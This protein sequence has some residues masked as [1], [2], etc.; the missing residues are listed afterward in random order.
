MRILFSRNFTYAKFRE[1][2]ALVKFPNLQYFNGKILAR[3]P[4]HTEITS[5]TEIEMNGWLDKFKRLYLNLNL[6][7]I[8]TVC[9]ISRNIHISY[10]TIEYCVIRLRLI[11][12][13]YP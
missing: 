12:A 11:T 9:S 1:N 4:L 7:I 13:A 6:I 10:T 8:F 3:Q 5:L 2:K